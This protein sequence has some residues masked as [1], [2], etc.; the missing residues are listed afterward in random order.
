MELVTVTGAGD[1][2]VQWAG[3][4]EF[5]IPEAWILCEDSSLGNLSTAPFQGPGRGDGG[6]NVLIRTYAF[7]RA[8][9]VF[10][11]KE[12]PWNCLNFRPHKTELRPHFS[13]HP[14]LHI[15]MLPRARVTA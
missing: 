13:Q 4:E 14:S 10:L 12:G 15:K 6:P 9:K 11:L 1:S 8:A 7:V 3:W 5:S 2:R